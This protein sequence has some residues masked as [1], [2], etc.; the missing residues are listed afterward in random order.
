MS[1]WGTIE[2]AIFYLQIPLALV[3]IALVVFDAIG[4]VFNRFIDGAIVICAW[5]IVVLHVWLSRK[6][7]KP[8]GKPTPKRWYI[9][10][11]VGYSIIGIYRTVL[12]LVEHL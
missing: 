6:K 3:Y 10:I 4:V 12:W 1:E 2:K 9:V 7:T 5:L 8:D 11:I